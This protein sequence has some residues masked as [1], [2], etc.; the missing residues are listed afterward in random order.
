MKEYQCHKIV[1]AARIIGFRENV[2]NPHRP[3]DVFY[4]EVEIEAENSPETLYLGQD[5]FARGVPACGDYLVMYDNGDGSEPYFSWS[6]E[7]TF[8]EGY[9]LLEFGVEDDEPTASAGHQ[10]EPPNGIENIVAG[11]NSR[12]GSQFGWPD[13]FIRAVIHENGGF[14]LRIGWGDIQFYQDGSD[15]GG[16]TDLIKYK[17]ASVLIDAI[18]LL[19]DPDYVPEAEVEYDLHNRKTLQNIMD[20]A[21][22]YAS[23]E[24]QMPSWKN[25]YMDLAKASDRLDAMLARVELHDGLSDKPEETREPASID[26]TV[27]DTLV[28]ETVEDEVETF[29]VS[30]IVNGK[31]HKFGFIGSNPEISYA[32]VAELAGKPTGVSTITY[33]GRNSN[34]SLTRGQSI[35][36]E[37]G[38]IFN[39]FYT[40]NA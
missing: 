26:E 37:E 28:D 9:T 24:E 40:D 32:E 25:A 20:R 18:S 29:E 4:T 19:N 39:A 30:F 27:V 11:I 36:L 33:S 7:K 12:F 22:D 31:D 38:M 21:F 17:N 16:G 14:S 1:R 13:G 6:P 23:I 8:K 2:K 15:V 10:T 3:G 5:I 35:S 34:G